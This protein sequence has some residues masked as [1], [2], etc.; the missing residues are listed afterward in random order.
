M[1]SRNKELSTY[2]SEKVLDRLKEITKLSKKPNDRDKFFA[3]GSD[4]QSINSF[5]ELLIECLYEWSYL[6]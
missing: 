6:F 2:V 3:K 4:K 5:F 1:D